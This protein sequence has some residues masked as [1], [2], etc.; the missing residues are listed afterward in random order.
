MHSVVNPL[1]SALCAPPLRLG[2]VAYH[3]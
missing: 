3:G 2:E 1:V